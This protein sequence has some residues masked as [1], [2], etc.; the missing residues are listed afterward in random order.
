MDTAWKKLRKQ[1]ERER[2]S[3]ADANGRSKDAK[4]V[5]AAL[6]GAYGSVLRMM[7][8]IEQTAAQREP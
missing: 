1:V 7:D 3:Y 5:F 4:A 6:E 8:K 2:K